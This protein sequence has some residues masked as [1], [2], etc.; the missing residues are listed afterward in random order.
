[1]GLGS[2]EHCEF[3]LASSKHWSSAGSNLRTGG[4][5]DWRKESAAAYGSTRVHDPVYVAYVYVIGL[6]SEG[7]CICVYACMWACKSLWNMHACE[8]TLLMDLHTYIIILGQNTWQ[9]KKRKVHFSRFHSEPVVPRQEGHSGRIWHRKALY[10]RQ[11]RSREQDE[12]CG[13]RQACQDTCSET[14]LF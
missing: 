2:T 13:G 9:F 8:H 12:G 14:H 5:E 7:T 1:M 4:R 6:C 11:P 10:V 3:L